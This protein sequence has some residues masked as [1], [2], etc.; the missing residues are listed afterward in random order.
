M[1]RRG[2][3]ALVIAFGYV[4]LI[5]GELAMLLVGGQRDVT[6]SAR[7]RRGRP[8][9]ALDGVDLVL[10]AWLAAWWWQAVRARHGLRYLNPIAFPA[11]VALAEVL[12][13]G[14]AEAVGARPRA[15]ATSTATWR[16]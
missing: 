13:E 1:R 10:A 2:W 15:R 8:P 3:L 4:C 6:S 12:I 5:A 11:L 14:A 16:R 9:A 7:D